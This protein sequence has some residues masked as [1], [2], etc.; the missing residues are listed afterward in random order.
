IIKRFSDFEI[1]KISPPLREPLVRVLLEALADLKY[2]EVREGRAYATGRQ[3]PS[4][5]QTGH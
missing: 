3:P 2:I 5:P 1:N 4:R